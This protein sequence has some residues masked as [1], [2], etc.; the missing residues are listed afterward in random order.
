MGV[1]CPLPSG[2]DRRTDSSACSPPILAHEPLSSDRL[3]NDKWI[4]S[5]LPPKKLHTFHALARSHLW[6]F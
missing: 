6:A 3:N 4:Y 1:N 2:G 5:L